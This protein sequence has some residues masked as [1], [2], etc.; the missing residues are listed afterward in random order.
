MFVAE[1]FAAEARPIRALADDHRLV[2]SAFLPCRVE[3][4][5]AVI[6]V[7]RS[8]AT[9]TQMSCRY[10]PRLVPHRPIFQALRFASR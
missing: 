4:V 5:D 8:D 7:Q 10:F 6:N 1:R 3:D 2:V 9:A